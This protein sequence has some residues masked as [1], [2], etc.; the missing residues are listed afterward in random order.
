M[1]YNYLPIPKANSAFMKLKTL[2]LLVSEEIS[3][4]FSQNLAS[5][6]VL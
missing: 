6:S 4:F 3:S 1:G 2:V 5:F